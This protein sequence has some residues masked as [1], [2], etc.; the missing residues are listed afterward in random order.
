MMALWTSR[1]P[2]TAQEQLEL[3]PPFAEAEQQDEHSGGSLTKLLPPLENVGDC[4]QPAQGVNAGV[5]IFSTF[6]LTDLWTLFPRSSWAEH[7]GYAKSPCSALPF[8]KLIINK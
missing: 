7:S 6:C 2:N 4:P 3:P 5:Y 1:H 8:V